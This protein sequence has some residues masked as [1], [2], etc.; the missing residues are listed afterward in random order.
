MH[1]IDDH[2]LPRKALRDYPV[3][4]HEDRMFNTQ[5]EDRLRD[6]ATWLREQAYKNN[7]SP[8]QM[9]NLFYR[10]SM[11]ST[12][13]DRY[14]RGEKNLIWDRDEDNLLAGPYK[15][16]FKESAISI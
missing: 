1:D 12:I 15:E 9:T 11:N 2:V 5:E 16:V 8:D 7:I 4:Q 6:K 13:L 3:Y 14:F 10:C